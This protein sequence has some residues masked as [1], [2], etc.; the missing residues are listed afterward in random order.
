MVTAKTLQLLDANNYNISPAVCV[1]SLY[2]ERSQGGTTYRMAMRN[3]ILVAGDSITLNAEV[4]DNFTSLK[5]VA[6]PYVFFRN[7][8]GT[9]TENGRIIQVDSAVVNIGPA[10]ENALLNDLAPYLKIEDAENDYIRRDAENWATNKI[11]IQEKGGLDLTAQGSNSEINFGDGEFVI[12]REG[13]QSSLVSQ[14]K[15]NIRASNEVVLEHQKSSTKVQ[16]DENGFAVTSG[17]VS[18]GSTIKTTI[19]SE[20]I[21]IRGDKITIE[22]TTGNTAIELNN[23]SIG[24]RASQVYIYD[25]YIQNPNN[26][27]VASNRNHE[28]F[29]KVEKSGAGVAERYVW[30]T[31]PTLDLLDTKT[32][33]VGDIESLRSDTKLY[34]AHLWGAALDQANYGGIEQF[35]IISTQENGANN[36]TDVCA[37]DSYFRSIRSGN[38]AKRTIIPCEGGTPK[39]STNDFIDLKTINGKSLLTNTQNEDIALLT[40]E[41]IKNLVSVQY[42][43]NTIKDQQYKIFGATVSQIRQLNTPREAATS[44]VT[45]GEATISYYEG[46]YYR[47]NGNLYASGYYGTSDERLKRDIKPISPDLPKLNIREFVWNDSSVKSYGFIAQD[48]EKDFPE[49]VDTG[50]DGFKRVSY[51]AA[52]SL[53]VAQLENEI[54]SL[55][56]L[57]KEM[58]IKG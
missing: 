10:F 1:D 50:D 21:E 45:E 40:M 20:D 24:L 2:F 39:P 55:K 38:V 11:R 27:G 14:H 36:D 56:S 23:T 5:N 29:L 3:R 48:I 49:L 51:N 42:L 35:N 43:D 25:A 26:S 22:N 47:G 17:N 30:A 46:L 4:P 58:Q 16:L 31:T 37:K 41:N 9:N 12:A 18:I 52:L 8:D 6:L 33:D 32:T 57:I 28:Y 19:L 15:L 44:N 54:E 13:E 7:V 34:L 53:K